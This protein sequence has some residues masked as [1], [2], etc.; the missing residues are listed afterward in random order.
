MHAFADGGVRP[1]TSKV[2][3]KVYAMIVTRSRDD[4]PKPFVP[5]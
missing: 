1:I 4:N 5:P 2:D 3:P